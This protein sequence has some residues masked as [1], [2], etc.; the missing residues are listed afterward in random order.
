MG[1]KFF[2]SGKKKLFPHQQREGRGGKGRGEVISQKRKKKIM[3]LSL[4]LFLKP[5][6]GRFEFVFFF[7]PII[8]FP[9]NYGGEKIWGSKSLGDLH[10]VP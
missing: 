3:G 4:G 8:F 9:S 2:F 5:K 7:P 6:G 1:T 10:F